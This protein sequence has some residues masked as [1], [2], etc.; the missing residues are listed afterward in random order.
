MD[1]E[2]TE[3]E[4]LKPLN[5]KTKEFLRKL[6]RL[7]QRASKDVLSK[8]TA[9]FVKL[10]QTEEPTLADANRHGDL[11]RIKREI[12]SLI[13]DLSAKVKAMIIEL[14]EETYESSYS[15][16]IIGVLAALGIKLARPIATLNQ[17]NLPAEWAPG[18][19]QRAI[20]SKQMDKA[21]ETDRKKT[22]Q[23][24]HKTIERGFIERKRFAQVA[25]ELQTDVGLS[26][27]R[28]KRIANTEMH[29][30]REKATLDA[31]KKAQSR[32]INMK[33]I[34]HN[35]G[36]ERVRETKHADHVHLE[37]QER[38][39]NQL[40]DLGINKNGVHVT[41]EAPGQSGDPSNDINCRCFATY[42]PVL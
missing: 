14:L 17:P 31:A 2:Q 13:S 29:R 3:K 27:N 32:G 8:L 4:L 1:K 10:D 7:F 21:I 24:I 15:W 37:G 19:V 20:K 11:S 5:C 9:L 12:T 42:E 40:F 34:W 18:D 33:K 35:V 38:M 41:A 22:I 23:Q 25:K 39:V 16:L 6:K 28:S 26:Y 30:T 36:D